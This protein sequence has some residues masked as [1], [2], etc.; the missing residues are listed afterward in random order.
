MQ[1][2]FSQYYHLET[3]L[4]YRWY[5]QVEKQKEVQA[6]KASFKILSGYFVRLEYIKSTC[7]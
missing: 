3:K 4:A 6:A 1:Y 2:A 5:L 7:N